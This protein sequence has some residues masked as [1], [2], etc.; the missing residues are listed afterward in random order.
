VGQAPGRAL[1]LHCLLYLSADTIC[2]LRPRSGGRLARNRSDYVAVPCRPG[3]EV[4][5][6]DL[7]SRL[8]MA[9]LLECRTAGRVELR[10]ADGSLRSRM[11]AAMSMSIWR[12]RVRVV[13]RD[14]ASLPGLCD[15]ILEELPYQA[16][17]VEKRTDKLLSD[18]MAH[19]KKVIGGSFGGSFEWWA[20]NQVQAELADLGYVRIEI[21]TT[22]GRFRTRAVHRFVDDCQQIKVLD[23]ECTIA[24]QR[25]QQVWSTEQELCEALLADCTAAITTARNGGG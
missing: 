10:L 1:G 14:S 4:S 22:R 24:V 21:E 2:P 17:G 7:S 3:V 8:L 9:A 18:T 13:L 12:G 23:D 11:K 25:W 6:V 16:Y 15:R 20:I 5:A 19:S